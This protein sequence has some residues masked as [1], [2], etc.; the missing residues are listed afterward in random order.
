[1]SVRR[2]AAV[3]SA[4]ALFLGVGLGVGATTPGAALA[5]RA[6]EAASGGLRHAARRGAAQR[7]A[8]RVHH[9]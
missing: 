6:A 8:T 5:D 3:L 7:G 2:R 4:L 1:M 9:R